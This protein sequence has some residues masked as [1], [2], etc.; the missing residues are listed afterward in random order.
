MY[1]CVN[2]VYVYVC[3]YV[4][5]YAC[6]KRRVYMGIY[7]CLYAGVSETE[8]HS[9]GICMCAYVLPYTYTCTCIW[10]VCVFM[11]VCMDK[12]ACVYLYLCVLVRVSV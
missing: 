5:M 12:K 8:K 9:E 4:C 1:V 2:R 11:Y 3:M 10:F 7:V 6:I